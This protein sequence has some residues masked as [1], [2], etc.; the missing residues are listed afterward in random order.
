[1]MKI[2]DNKQTFTS[3]IYIKNMNPI[4]IWVI[5]YIYTTKVVPWPTIILH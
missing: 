4:T 5:L 2:T 1:M 3:E